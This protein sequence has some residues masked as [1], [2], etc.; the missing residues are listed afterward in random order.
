[1]IHGLANF[2]FKKDVLIYMF[3]FTRHELTKEMYIFTTTQMNHAA[4]T[5]K[6]GNNMLQ[7]FVGETLGNTPQ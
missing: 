2:K 7:T 1:M 3:R 5:E 6:S 4:H